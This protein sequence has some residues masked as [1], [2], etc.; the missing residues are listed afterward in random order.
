MAVVLSVPNFPFS[1]CQYQRTDCQKTPRRTAKNCHLKQ[2]GPAGFETHQVCGFY[3]V[4]ARTDD[5]KKGVPSLPKNGSICA[6]R[7]PLQ[8]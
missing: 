3:Y 5:L 4:I 2:K 7:A 1:N 6:V 8:K